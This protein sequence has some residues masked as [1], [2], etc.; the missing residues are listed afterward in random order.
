M[1]SAMRWL[2]AGLPGVLLAGCVY[3]PDGGYVRGDGY[4][5]AGAVYYESAPYAGYYY[6]SYYDGYSPP[7]GYSPWYGPGYYSIGIGVHGHH[8]GHHWHG[9]HGWGH[10]RDDA[11]SVPRRGTQPESRRRH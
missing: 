8:H 7:Y 9:G 5:A 2:L 1:T 10:D 6:G 3:Y 11:R 4:G